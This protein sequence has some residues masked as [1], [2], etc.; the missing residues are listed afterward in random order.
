MAGHRSRCQ[1]R[2]SKMEIIPTILTKDTAELQEKLVKIDGLVPWVQI[3]FI[4]GIFVANK[5]FDLENLE[6]LGKNLKKEVHLIVKEPIGWLGKCRYILADR[7]VAQVEI[8]SN[9]NDFYQEAASSGMQVGLALDLE[10]PIEKIPADIYPQLDLVLLMAVKAGWGGQDF[11]PKVLLK[12]KKVRETV[13]DLV[14]IGADG[15]LNEENII[16]CKKAGAT[17]F[18]VGKTFWEYQD[19]EKR[20]RQL[21]DLIS[22]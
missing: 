8:M 15:G 4:D 13:G 16:E 2:I 22:N 1:T 5:T 19:L 9:V 14:D 10:T 12:I 6:G 11:D 18:Y 7:V 21:I 3:D 17:I 20:Y